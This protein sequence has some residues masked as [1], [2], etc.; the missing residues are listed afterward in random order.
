M[1]RIT[2]VCP[3][4]ND[5]AT[6][7]E[8]LDSLSE[9]EPIEVLFIDDASTDKATTDLLAR[10]AQADHITV[11]RHAENQGVAHGINTGLREAKTKFVFFMGSDDLFEPGALGALADA[12]EADD[13]A[14]AAWGHYEFFEDR[15]DKRLTPSWDPWRLTYNNSWTGVAMVRRAELL[16][17]GGANPDRLYEDWDMWLKVASAGKHGVVIDRP[18]FRYRIRYKAGRRSS[19]A[20]SGFRTEYL[21]MKTANRELFKRRSKLVK[22]SSMPL[23]E[24]TKLR[25]M[26]RVNLLLPSWLRHRLMEFM[27]RVSSRRQAKH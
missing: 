7:E 19:H 1:T 25:F 18:M 15:T 20:K 3:C 23:F 13:D 22:Q 8:M 16:A 12:L 2:V 14:I 6:L 10:L 11:I 21:K 24:R 4:Y 9:T 5:G 17:L 27:A 26:V